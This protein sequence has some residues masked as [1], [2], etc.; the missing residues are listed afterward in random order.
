MEC[1]DWK[2]HET[3]ICEFCVKK[4]KKTSNEAAKSFTAPQQQE[5]TASKVGSFVSDITYS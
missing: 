1:E 3:T 4:K 5:H 2:E